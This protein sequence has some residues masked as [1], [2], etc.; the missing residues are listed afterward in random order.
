M[1]KETQELYIEKVEK[2]N[3]ISLEN[4]SLFLSSMLLGVTSLQVI[5]ALASGDWGQ[6]DAL[7]LTS[8]WSAP[9]MAV[10]V[11]SMVKAIIRKT[12]AKARIEEIKAFFEHHGLVLEDE[13]AK[14]RSM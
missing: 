14:G 13:I 10:S 8:L 4:K 2:Y 11:F 5:S 12:D 3:D 7:S 1:K 6:F 9:L